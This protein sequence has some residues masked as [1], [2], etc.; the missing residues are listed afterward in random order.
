ML[1]TN[2]IRWC[3]LA[4]IVAGVLRGIASVIPRTTP[5]IMALYFFIDVFLLLGSIGTYSFQRAEIRLTGTLGFLLQLVGALILIT[6]DV[7]LLGS[8]AY[9][10]GALMFAAGLDLLAAGSWKGKKL[11]RWILILWVLSTT[12]APIGYFTGG[13]SVLFLVS[14]MLFGIAFAGGGIT[15]WF[16]RAAEGSGNSPE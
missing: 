16:S 3:G 4:A 15:V 11:P 10:V 12:L 9:P 14:G 8:A 2:L 1:R 7:A 5:R 6:R 13:Q